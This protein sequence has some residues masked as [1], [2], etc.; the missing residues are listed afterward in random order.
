MTYVE[1]FKRL[2]QG[3]TE[4]RN[5]TKRLNSCIGCALHD[6]V[7][8]L[9]DCFLYNTPCDY[10]FRSITEKRIEKFLNQ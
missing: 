1:F 8:I 10:D 7:E 3:C 2:K 5:K 6:D 9:N 4:H